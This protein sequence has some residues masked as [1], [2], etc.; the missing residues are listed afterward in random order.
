MKN[1]IHIDYKTLRKINPEAAR[2]AVLEYFASNR[3]NIAECARTFGITRPIVYK[4][5]RKKKEGNLSDSSRTPLSQPKRTAGKIE[6][7]V[8]EAKNKFEA[9]SKKYVEFLY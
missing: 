7:K 4:I 2:A 6:D 1:G 5:L 9:K 3:E 8:I